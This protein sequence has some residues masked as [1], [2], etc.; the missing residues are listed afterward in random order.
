MK[1]WECYYYTVFSSVNPFILVSDRF[2]IVKAPMY[3][4]L[5]GRFPVVNTSHVC[6]LDRASAGKFSIMNMPIYIGFCLADFS[7]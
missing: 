7:C 2:P 4:I 6:K 5:S 1:R 3:R